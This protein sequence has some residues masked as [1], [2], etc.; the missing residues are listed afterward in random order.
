M[1]SWK[2][3]RPKVRSKKEVVDEWET[4]DIDR[5]EQERGLKRR[6][7][8]WR[9][10]ETEN[11]I[12]KAA[13][14]TALKNADKMKNVRVPRNIIEEAWL[15]YDYVLANIM[16]RKA[17][18]FLDKIRMGDVKLYNKLLNI[19]ISPYMKEQIDVM[20]QYFANGLAVD[21]KI[22]LPDIVKE[23]RKLKGIRTKFTVK[24][25]GDKDYDL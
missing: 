16:D 4:M 12:K 23:Y 10:I 20:V 19:F 13:E 8:R 15:K 9:E 2:K 14:E 11:L 24:R 6:A 25:K 1:P 5:D 18:E 21:E 22:T 17:H 7:R 3:T